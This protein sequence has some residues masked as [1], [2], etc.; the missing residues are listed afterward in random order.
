MSDSTQ[1][2]RMTANGIPLPRW[3]H[4]WL[5]KAMRH[6]GR[7]GLRRSWERPAVMS[8]GLSTALTSLVAPLHTSLHLSLSRMASMRTVSTMSSQDACAIGSVPSYS[9]I[10]AR[11]WVRTCSHDHG[12]YRSAGPGRYAQHGRVCH[13]CPWLLDVCLSRL[14]N[15]QPSDSCVLSGY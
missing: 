2:R 5:R 1:E 14:P 6:V 15:L 9:T 13:F 11:V 10:R 7:R 12:L 8:H 4:A 3:G